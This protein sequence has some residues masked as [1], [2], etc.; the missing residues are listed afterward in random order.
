MARFV[1]LCA[2]SAAL[3]KRI[4][5]A[6][7]HT[8]IAPTTRNVENERTGCTRLPIK[9]GRGVLCSEADSLTLTHLYVA[10]VFS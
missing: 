8:V 1:K 10:E 7:Q 6:K 4:R 5:S 2:R 9:A 3:P